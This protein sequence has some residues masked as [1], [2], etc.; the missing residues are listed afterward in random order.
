[1]IAGAGVA[2]RRSEVERAGVA[3]HE[4][5]G[6]IDQ[7]GIGIQVHAG[8][9]DPDSG[10]HWRWKRFD[11][12]LPDTRGGVARAEQEDGLGR[13]IASN[14]S[15]QLRLTVEWHHVVDR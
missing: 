14:S 9:N 7:C 6:A 4:E 10:T 3:G 13:S 12:A 11:E 2:S 5:I 8:G 1:M 15:E